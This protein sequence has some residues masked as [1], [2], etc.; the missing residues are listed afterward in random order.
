M[1]PGITYIPDYLD[2]ETHDRFLFTVDQYPWRMSVDHRVQ[3]YGYSYNHSQRA[4]FRVGDIP[5]WAMPL[6]HRLR[7]DEHVNALPNQLVVND[8]RPGAGI[9]DHMDQAVFGEV[10]ISVSLASTCMMRFTREDS[11]ASEEILL[12]PRSLLA[13][14]GESRWQWRH[15]IP[16]RTSDV[17][18]GRELVRSRRV[19]LTFRAVPE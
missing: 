5:A 16:P 1:I 2:H 15:G 7:Q 11:A 3:V 9:F 8:Y 14:A 12:E 13:L 10:V 4:A 18:Q 17:W 6:A 19:S